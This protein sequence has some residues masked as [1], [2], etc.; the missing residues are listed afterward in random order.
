M[1][2]AFE[3]RMAFFSLFGA[4]PRFALVHFAFEFMEYF[5]DVP[6]VFIK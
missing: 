4:G 6:A 1:S 2:Q 3:D 5:L